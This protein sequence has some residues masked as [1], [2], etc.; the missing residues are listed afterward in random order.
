MAN[1]S[2]FSIDGVEYDVGSSGGGLV[3]YS[4]TINFTDLTSYTFISYLV[5]H[6]DGTYEKIETVSATNSVS[7][8][9]YIVV[10][11]QMK[12]GLAGTRETNI[13][14]IFGD[15]NYFYSIQTTG[16]NWTLEFYE[17]L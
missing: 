8:A 6:S 13:R 17:N 5:I 9:V 3:G 7:D 16:D 4:G 1:I 11:L 12:Y 14:Y 10:Q 2:K 15:G